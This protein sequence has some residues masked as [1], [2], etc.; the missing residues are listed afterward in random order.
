MLNNGGEDKGL[1]DIAQQAGHSERRRRP[2][3][4]AGLRVHQQRLGNANIGTQQLF[5]TT[6]YHYADN[7]TLIRGRHMMKMGGQHPAPADERV[8]LRQQRPQRL[9]RLQRPVHR[10]PTRSTRRGKLVG[11]ADF[12][13]GLPTDLGRGLSTGTWGQRKTIYGFYFQDDWRVTNNLTLNLG[14]ALGVPHAAGRGEGPPG[15]LRPVHAAQLELA[16][17]N[18]NSRALYNRYK[19]DFQPRVGF[20]YTSGHPEQEMVLRGAYTIS[21]FMEGTGTNLRLPLNP[22]FNSEFADAV[23]HAD[24]HPA[25]DHARSGTLRTERRTIRTRARPSAC[26]IP[27]CGPPKS[28]SGTSRWSSSCPASN[29]LTRRLRRT[30][31]HAPDGRHAVLP[32]AARQRPDSAEPVPGRQSDPDERDHADLRHAVRAP[33][34]STTRCRPRCASASAWAWN[35][36]SSYTWSKGM[37]DSIGYYGEGGQA[38]GQSAYMQNLYDRKA[39]VGPDVLRRT[40]TTSSASFVYETAVRP[41]EEVRLATGTAA[42]DGVLGGW[43][44]GGI[45]TAHT[46]FPL[47]IK[48]S[49]DPLRHGRP[50]LP[51]QRDR[52]AERSAPDR[53]GRAVPGPDRLRRSRRPARSATP[54]SASFADPA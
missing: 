10:R 52:H 42:V 38:G 39:R 48:M 19:K 3:V 40:S 25:R 43:Q 51:R 29:V 34:R 16:G 37:S 28:S 32:E 53:T 21:S 6:T 41:E 8:L 17:Q 36:R 30:A 4:A 31:R 24:R 49:G 12:V 26:G 14:P 54:A 11:E 2:A 33:T 44:M 5:A 1:G 27:T 22:P 20:A 46:G 13:L 50:Q 7:L 18:G 23:Q 35:T 47:T 9:H 45:F 15:Q